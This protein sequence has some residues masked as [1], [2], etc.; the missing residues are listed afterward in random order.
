[1]IFP[2]D[3]S[4][5]P[6]SMV[7]RALL[8]LAIVWLLSFSETLQRLD[9]AFYDTYISLQKTV[10]DKEIAIVAIDERSLQAFG[11]WPWSREIH[12]ES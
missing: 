3:R 11:H 2:L 9:W 8:L 5:L 7:W 10:P 12:A 6:Q 1:M 4:V